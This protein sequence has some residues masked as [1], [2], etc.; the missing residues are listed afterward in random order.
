MVS[1]DFEFLIGEPL[2]TAKVEKLKKTL[3]KNHKNLNSE[4]FQSEIE[5]FKFKASFLSNNLMK[6]KP[7]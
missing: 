7:S 3:K 1:L 4:E 2:S 5:S 6:A